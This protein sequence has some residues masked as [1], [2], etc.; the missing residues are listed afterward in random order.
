[1]KKL[2]FKVLL[3][4]S[5]GV[6]TAC[7]TIRELPMEQRKG[8]PQGAEYDLCRDL[9]K[10]FMRNDGKTFLSYLPDEMREKFSEKQFKASRKS[11]I[12]SM[13]EPISFQYVTA[14]ELTALTPHIWKIR[15]E[16]TDPR[17]GKKFTSEILFRIITGKM[18]GKPVVIGFQFL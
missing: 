9:L 11:V 13:G 17:N 15:F 4:V 3:I 6:L 10:A 7:T 1:M 8:E 12:D 2:L 16:R 5:A 14:L 18:N